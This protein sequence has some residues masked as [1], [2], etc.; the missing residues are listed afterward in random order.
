MGPSRSIDKSASNHHFL[1]IAS[2]LLFVGLAWYLVPHPVVSVGLAFV[3]I[4]VLFTLRFPVL[5]A[6]LF[7]VFSYFRIHE[8]F[9]MLMPF[10][11]PLLL[12]LATLFTFSWHIFISRNIQLKGSKELTC[13]YLFFVAVTLGVMFATNRPASLSY[14]TSTYVKIAIMTP[15]L[16][17]ILTEPRHF[18]LAIRMFCLAGVMVALVAISNKL[19]GIGLVEGTRVTIGRSFQSVLGDPN[20]LSLVLLFPLSFALALFLTPKIAT[21]ERLFGMVAVLLIVWAIIATQSRGGILGIAS[22]LGIF[23]YR[24]VKSKA[25]LMVGG[26]VVLAI[27]YVVA[28]VDGRQSGGAAEDGIDESAMG[29]IYAWGAA[30]RMALD[31]PFTGVGLDNFLYNYF[32][33][34]AHWDGMNH[35]VHSTWFGV[36]AETGFLGVTLFI[37]MIVVMLKTAATTLYTVAERRE[38]FP[39]ISSAM[40]EG[41]FAGIVAFCVSGS[42]LTQGFTWP[43]YILVALTT[44]NSVFVKQ[45]ASS[46]STEN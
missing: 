23:A 3:P 14:F 36:L 31:N 7:I 33:Y 30:Y 46:L 37:I 6:L 27:L 34:S 13:F 5:F 15:V 20:D 42:F 40:S 44:A 21:F 22:V 28:G 11:I 1:V 8:A 2:V 17:S 18:K 26:M 39:A 35:A 12:S 43:V 10:R 45:H 38:Q 32:F 9:P 4:A 16:A 24:R 29:R 25:L 19:A 41:I